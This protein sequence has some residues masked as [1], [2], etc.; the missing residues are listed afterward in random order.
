MNEESPTRVVPKRD[1]F[2][3]KAIFVIYEWDVPL[4]QHPEAGWF[5]WYGG[6]P[7]PYDVKR[8]KVDNNWDANSFEEWQKLVINS[9]ESMKQ[10]G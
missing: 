8:L 10:Y 5:N 4:V 9:I 6:I 2:P 7:R 1:D 3:E